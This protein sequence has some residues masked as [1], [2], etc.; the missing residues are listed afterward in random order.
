MKTVAYCENY[1]WTIWIE[2]HPMKAV[3]ELYGL[4]DLIWNLY[5]SSMNCMTKKAVLELY[6]LNDLVWN[7]YYS[8]MN[9]MTKKAVLEL[10]GLNDLVWNLYYSSMNCMTK[11]AALELYGL[12]DLIWNL[13][14]SSMNCMTKKA[15]F[16]LYELCDIYTNCI[17]T[18]RTVTCYEISISTVLTKWYAIKSVFELCALNGALWNLYLNY[19]DWISYYEIHIWTIWTE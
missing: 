3:L 19:M 9:C 4:N 8:S 11:K 17:W 12:N 2:W 14:Y 16:Q 6:G 1:I 13:Y 15:V 5:Y 18:K 7:L 10:Y